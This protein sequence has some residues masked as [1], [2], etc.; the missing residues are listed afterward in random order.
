MGAAGA[1][2][3]AIAAMAVATDTIP[4]TRNLRNIDDACTGIDHVIGSARRTP[5]EVAL[6][7]SF[8]LGGHNACLA[9]GP[10]DGG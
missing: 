7:C 2:E 4:A 6:S 5:V 9:L 10:G 1:L 8:G 3:G